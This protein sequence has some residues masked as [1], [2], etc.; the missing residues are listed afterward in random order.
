LKKIKGIL[1]ALSIFG[2]SACTT[3]DSIMSSWVGTSIDEFIAANGAPDSRIST[4]DGGRVYTWT[5]FGSNQYG[6]V[7][8]CRQTFVTDARGIIRSW[9]YNGCPKYHFQ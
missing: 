7:S 4:S 1:I 8:Q 3:T 5:T 6:G 2:I 9:S